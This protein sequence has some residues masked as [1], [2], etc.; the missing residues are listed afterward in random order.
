MR[1]VLIG[2]VILLAAPALAQPVVDPAAPWQ[3][4]INTCVAEWNYATPAQR[5]TMSYRQFTTKCVSGQ[6]ALPTK[7]K[8]ICTNGNTSAATSPD[9]A[10]AND[11][12]VARWT[13]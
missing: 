8:A 3:Q 13:E 5:G 4:R 12:G 10:C 2:I 6:S 11:G 1:T 7:T 9:G